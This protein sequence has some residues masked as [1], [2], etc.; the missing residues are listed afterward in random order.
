MAED[1]FWPGGEAEVSPRSRSFTDNDRAFVMDTMNGI[2]RKPDG[3]VIRHR[4][5]PRMYL[6][7]EALGKDDFPLMLADVL[8]RQLLAV[9]EAKTNPF[10]PLS[11]RR[12]IR[13]FSIVKTL[14]YTG[15]MNT[16]KQVL[17]EAPYLDAKKPV[18]GMTQYQLVKWGEVY[19]LQWE[20]YLNDNLGLFTRLPNVMASNAL[21]T[22]ISRFLSTMMTTT[23]WRT[24]TAQGAPAATAFSAAALDT[25]LAAMNGAVA[26]YRDNNIPMRNVPRY[27]VYADALERI[28]FET[29]M[30]E[31]VVWTAGAGGTATRQGD[32]NYIR[33]KGLIPIKMEQFHRMKDLTADPPASI[34]TDATS[35]DTMWGI[36]SEN[37]PVIE[38]GFLA[39]AETPELWLKSPNAQKLGGGVVSPFDGDFESDVISYRMRFPYEAALVLETTGGSTKGA[40]VSNGH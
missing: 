19:R 6:V 20:M 30:S 36:F 12:S 11:Q 33:S 28:V 13:D 18:E 26:G 40:W 35:V 15:M 21:N 27:L 29:L 24:F 38:E 32:F 39:G 23:G 31:K 17:P 4:G 7:H 16:L 34:V 5:I 14:S 3:I 25:A 37:I 2:Q 9:Y 8:D 22:R 1:K 10:E